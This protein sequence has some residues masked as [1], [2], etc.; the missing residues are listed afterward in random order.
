[1]LRFVERIEPSQIVHLP[2]VLYHWRM[3]E[4]ST[5]VTVDNKHYAVQAGL[6]AV[7]EALS[8]RGIDAEVTRLEHVPHYYV[9]YALPNPIP[10]VAIIIPTR[11][12]LDVLRPCIQSVLERTSYPNFE[13]VVVDN[14]SEEQATLAYLEEIETMGVTVIRDP[15]PFNFARIN[16]HATRGLGADYFCFLNND[17]TVITPDWLSEMVREC[18]QDKVGVV[19]A[20]LLYPDGTNQHAGVVL[21]IGGEKIA[22][23]AFTGTPGEDPAYFGRAELPHELSAVTAACMLTRRDLFE[24]L[25]GFDAETFAVAFNDIDYCLRARKAGYKVIFTPQARLTHHESKTRGFDLKGE[26]RKRYLTEAEAMKE[27]WGELLSNDP[28]Y[29]PNLALGMA[30]FSISHRPRRSFPWR[31]GGPS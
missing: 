19:G 4:G 17:T 18:A 5:S 27:R 16:N 9:R 20:K 30:P 3:L 23:H 28:F 13:V 8:R 22:G 12:G 24:K 29:S 7:S 6:R 14:G 26:R 15:Q 1:M 2:F 25:G 21:G 11:D 31:N 10:R